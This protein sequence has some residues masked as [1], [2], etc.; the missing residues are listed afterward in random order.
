MSEFEINQ[1]N[2]RETLSEN[3]EI[4][5]KLQE[6][7]ENMYS[8]VSVIFFFKAKVDTL[9]VAVTVGHAL[10]WCLRTALPTIS[11]SQS[12]FRDH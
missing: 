8:E 11:I 7:S 10:V 3:K 4:F 5:Y 6:H 9:M 2:M 1:R 12:A